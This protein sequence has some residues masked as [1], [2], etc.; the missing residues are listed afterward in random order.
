MDE[1]ALVL[2]RGNGGISTP[3]MGRI[4]CGVDC[5]LS[6]TGRRPYEST[7]LTWVDSGFATFSCREEVGSCDVTPLV[8]REGVS[9]TVGLLIQVPIGNIKTE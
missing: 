4:L 6:R 7:S 2:C 1:F 9:S 8:S 3:F 5:A